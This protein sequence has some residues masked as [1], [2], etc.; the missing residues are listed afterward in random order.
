[1]RQTKSV[2]L[3]DCDP[4]EAKTIG[5]MFNEQGL[6]SFE[7]TCVGSIEQAEVYLGLHSVSVVFLD[8]DGFPGDSCLEVLRRT[9]AIAPRASL[10]LLTGPEGE[11]LALRALEEGAQDYLIKGHI[12][13]RDLVHVMR[14]TIAR[15]TLEETLFN[16]KSRAQ[17]TL[18]CIDDA[19]ICTD[20][21]GN[22]TFLNP[23][24]ER[25]TGWS[26]REA[27]GRPLSEAFQIMDAA[28][29]E[30]A[31]DPTKKAIG[32]GRLTHLPINCILTRRDGHQ[33]F[34]EDSVAPILDSAGKPAGAVLVFRDVTEARALAEKLTQLAEHDSLTGLPNR[35]LLND[36]L[37]QAI[38]HAARRKTLVA[39]LFL[40]LDGFKHI[41]DSLGHQA[42]DKLLETIST[43]LQ[44]CVRAP[45][46]VS[47]HGGDEFVFLILDL[48]DP[49]DAAITAQRLLEVVALPLEIGTQELQ[50][51]ASIGISVY[52]DDGLEA[53]TL[54]KNADT[55]MYQVKE[56]GRQSFVFF[57]QEMNVKT[58]AKRSIAED[59]RHALDRH[60]LTLLYQPIVNVKSGAIAGAEA[61][62][63]WNHPTRGSVAPEIFIPV[64]ED[65]G[66][67]LP[68]GK[69]VLREACAQ[70][71]AW[72]DAGLPAITMSVNV[73]ARQFRNERF[74]ESLS[75]ILDEI[76]LSPKFLD[77]EITETVLM[78]RAHFG[79]H[80]LKRLR[81]RGLQVAIDDFGTGYSS[82]SYLQ[83]LPL[84]V[85][86]I[87][88]SFVS[89][90]AT[91]ANG[92]AIV[93]AIIAMG[94]S[95]NL[96]VIAEGIETAEDLAF[97]KKSACDEAQGFFFSPP[98]PAGDFARLHEMQVNESQKCP[99]S[100][101]LFGEAIY[102]LASNHELI[103]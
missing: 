40:D 59:L 84:D 71:K 62:L 46:T 87:D 23:V 65:T 79:A 4:D 92:A 48:N 35:L 18:E 36:R 37:G 13:P 42:G 60:E 100:A 74:L 34:I 50:V 76:G 57:K 19:V 72:A 49:A 103:H 53:E 82:L 83:L 5:T 28:T 6:C 33:V 20:L 52:P 95:L 67:I 7:L 32:Q 9:L 39:V 3:L 31:A 30:L 11:S 78:D 99:E 8:M 22:V 81:D 27:S 10:V 98:I 12:K 16:E 56:H 101:L 17:T 15:K 96:R 91:N 64:A 54:I 58:V 21:H 24:A 94:R 86:K 45:D 75:A 55:A 90:I 43:R 88:R 25:M 68:I 41:N 26:L 61:L 2:L 77:I 47:R 93:T 102:G 85:I 51:T 63:R 73:S 69:W 89:Q 14:S 70:A 44:R 66:L 38:A 80:E 1:M 97:L 29:G